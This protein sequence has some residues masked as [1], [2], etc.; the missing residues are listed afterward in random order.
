VE[1]SNAG[2][3]LVD[4]FFGESFRHDDGSPSCL[5]IAVDYPLALILITRDYFVCGGV[6]S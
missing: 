5:L 3:S 6:F 1:F 4:L 2:K